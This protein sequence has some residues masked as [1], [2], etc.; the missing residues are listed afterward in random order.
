MANFVVNPTSTTGV[1]ILAAVAKQRAKF[2]YL[3]FS[4]DSATQVTLT[5]FD[6]T[7]VAN[8]PRLVISLNPGIPVILPVVGREG[9]VLPKSWFT[10]G[11]VVECNC[12]ASHS[13]QVF[14][15][16]FME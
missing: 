12:S 16:A 9:T 1:Q 8:V 2:L 4:N 10:A 3:G 13:V 14:G 11:R 5:I 7:A 15:E 6:G